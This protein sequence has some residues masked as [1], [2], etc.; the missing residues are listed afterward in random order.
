VTISLLK[1][2]QSSFLTSR[3]LRDWARELELALKMAKPIARKLKNAL[4]KCL[5]IKKNLGPN[6]QQI[7]KNSA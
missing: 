3:T 5:L 4:L 7:E 6:Y 1:R 2:E